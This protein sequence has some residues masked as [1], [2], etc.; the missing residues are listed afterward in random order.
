MPVKKTAVHV[1][2]PGY[3][4][5]ERGLRRRDLFLDAATEMF[6]EK[7][8]EASSLQEIVGRAGGSLATLYRM[9]GNKEGLYQAVIERKASAAY[10]ELDLPELPNQPPE[11]VLF[12]VGRRLLDL[13]LV[14]DTTDLNR[15]MIAEAS[16][17][18]RL[19]EIFLEQAPNR[20]YRI[21]SGY[22]DHQVGQGVMQV[23]D[24]HLAAVQFVEMIK[25][26]VYMRQLLGERLQLSRQECDRRVRHAV[27]IFLRGTLKD[28]AAR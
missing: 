8:F 22:L 25:G 3:E 10:G 9:F 28:P 15:L 19:R 1:A 16:R 18:P 24:T 17:T 20:L 7:G 4:P 11:E 12:E 5:R 13:I 21:L 6:V 27:N 14:D 26:D 23:E 2:E